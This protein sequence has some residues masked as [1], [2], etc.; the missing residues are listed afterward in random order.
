VRHFAPPRVR[1]LRR[2]RALR[3]PPFI[4]SR[5]P[6]FKGWSDANARRRFVSTCA[7]PSLTPL[8]TPPPN[9]REPSTTPLQ[10]DASIRSNSDANE[11][12][13]LLER[14]PGEVGT[15]TPID[16]PPP[17]TGEVTRGGGLGTGSARTAGGRACSDRNMLEYAGARADPLMPPFTSLAERANAPE[18]RHGAYRGGFAA[19]SAPRLASLFEC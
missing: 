2:G 3:L 13:R 14:H 12:W 1:R 7:Q 5:R 19:D 15:S 6:D 10:P 9:W 8:S 18:R 16:S 17:W 11:L 4:P